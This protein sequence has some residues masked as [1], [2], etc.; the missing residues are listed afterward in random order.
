MSRF[1]KK[2]LHGAVNR[3]GEPTRLCFGDQWY[4][5]EE[6]LERWRDKGCW[7]EGESEKE[8]WRL[9]LQANQVW[10]VYQDMATGEWWSYK[11]YD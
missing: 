4:R 3:Q 10:E 6:C 7:W 9:L 5:V 8:F 1:V 11:V 2:Q